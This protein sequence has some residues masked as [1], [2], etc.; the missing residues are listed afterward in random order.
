MNHIS[1]HGVQGQK[2]G[3]KNGPPYP[4]NSNEKL[5]RAE[6]LTSQTLDKYKDQYNNLKHVK[7]TDN[8]NG[9]IYTKNGKVIAMVNT[10]KKPDGNI[11]IQGLEVFGDNKRQGLGKEL[12]N[13]AVNDLG[14]THLSVRKTNSIAKQLYNKYGFKTYESDDFMDYMKY[15]RENNEL[16]HSDIG[17][18]F[19][20]NCSDY[21]AH[22]G[23]QGQ[24]WGVRNGPPYPLVVKKI[25][26]SP[27]LQ[28]LKNAKSS[29]LDR[30]GKAPQYN[31]LYITGYSGSG[32][33]TVASFMADDGETDWINL[34]SYLN[35]M[36]E[37]SKRELQNKSFNLY[38]NKHVKNWKEFVPTFEKSHKEGIK[39]SDNII[40]AMDEFSARE[41]KNGRK[42][43]C[44]GVQILDKDF[45]R[46]DPN[47]YNDKPLIILGTSPK[48]SA[49]RGGERD[50]LD[51]NDI[52]DRF[53]WN[54]VMNQQLKSL[55]K[56]AQAKRGS[57]WIENYIKTV[58]LD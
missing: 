34:D 56:S 40:K 15:D 20:D 6:R 10:E 29:N 42:V 22:H 17:K 35:P 30:W 57:D 1:H 4:L 46:T 2:W 16:K 43:I 48:E 54:K 52:Q 53:D 7:I 39:I 33:S 45:L 8:T 31:T 5:G 36:S 23:V 11:W 26:S 19:I 55:E 50:E 14:A 47:F 58:E 28:R 51:E 9:R 49:I 32:K 44:E 27:A 24:K 12:L 37:E 21:L 13:V 41:Y 25:H 3:I 38:L 18:C